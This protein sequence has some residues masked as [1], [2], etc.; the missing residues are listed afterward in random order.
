MVLE[1]SGNSQRDTGPLSQLT[2]G[3][4]HIPIEDMEAWVFRSVETRMEEVVKNGKI[5][6][7]RNSFMLYRSAYFERAKKWY[8][9]NNPAVIN[10]VIGESWYKEAPEVRQLYELLARIDS[11]KH[12]LAHPGYKF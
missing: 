12:K 8:A 9:S 2:K 1:A 10:T 7:P 4:H 3:M 6:Q 11:D 5:T